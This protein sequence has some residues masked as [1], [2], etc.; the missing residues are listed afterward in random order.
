MNPLYLPKGTVRAIIILLMTLFVLFSIIQKLELPEIFCT[1][2]L[3]A[4]GYYF[5][6]R[7]E[8]NKTK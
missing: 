5:G 2:W 3:L 7:S 4:L 8:F 1:A 6:I